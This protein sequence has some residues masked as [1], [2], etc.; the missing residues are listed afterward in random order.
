[1]QTSIL[2]VPCMAQGKIRP[3]SSSAFVEKLYGS[4]AS[5][6]RHCHGPMDCFRFRVLFAARILRVPTPR[7]GWKI[8]FASSL[9]VHP[10]KNFR[11]SLFFSGRPYVFLFALLF[12]LKTVIADVLAC[13]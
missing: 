9:G 11:I 6:F 4:G 10:E 13:G 2:G 7:A 8:S 3:S 1:M 5:A 12:K